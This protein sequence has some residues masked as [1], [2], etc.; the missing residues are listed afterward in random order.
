MGSL[1]TLLWWTWTRQFT[2][3]IFEQK[4]QLKL[5]KDNSTDELYQHMTNHSK[6]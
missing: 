1:I 6:Q 3:G 5:N 4:P 2:K